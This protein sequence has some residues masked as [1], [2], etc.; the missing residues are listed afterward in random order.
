MN[1][2]RDNFFR[3]EQNYTALRLQQGVPLIDADWNENTEILRNELYSS[4]GA[5]FS[6]GVQPGTDSFLV[7]R[8]RSANGVPLEDND[9][10]V[11]NGTAII[12]G[13]PVTLN[14]GLPISLDSVIRYS[15]QPWINPVIAARDNVEVIELLETPTEDHVLLVY[16]DVWERDVNIDELSL[17][18]PER[19]VLENRDIGV[20]IVTSVRVKREFAVRVIRIDGK[21][22]DL[23]GVPNLPEASAGH[24]FMPLALIDRRVDDPIIP[25][26]RSEGIPRIT[27]EAANID[28][29]PVLN[30]KK[31]IRTIT[32]FPAFLPVSNFS[33]Q[34]STW[35]LL[36]RG[37][38]GQLTV[39][40]AQVR[41]NEAF[42]LL[43]LNFPEEVQLRNLKISV[44]GL[45]SGRNLDIRLFRMPLEAN[46]PDELVSENIEG[47]SGDSEDFVR[48]FPVSTENHINIVKN[49]LYSYA[50]IVAAEGGNGPVIRGI[51]IEYSS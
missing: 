43:P 2:S 17:E 36:Y 14:P 47:R 29:R 26:I 21:T 30:I 18:N 16:L 45:S 38:G 1:I 33:R 28:I 32:L 34:L 39:S 10:Y 27:Q 7:V 41:N 48:T 49:E 11:L 22:S 6:D 40:G 20:G 8:S 19:K 35:E 50:L 15:T 5:G 9:F 25:R 44:R 51:S 42:G 23:T 24:F 46:F 12:Q 37:I 4:L 13:H 31:G 3:P